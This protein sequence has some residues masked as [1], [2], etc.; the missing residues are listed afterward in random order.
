MKNETVL[1]T[2]ASGFIAVNAIAKL[3]AKGY[4]V[5]GSLRTMARQDEVRAMVQATG[6]QDVSGLEFVEADLVNANSW[7]LAMQ[8]VDYVMHIASPTPATRPD[9]ADAMVEMAVT[10][11]RNI[12]QA[13]YEEDVKRIVLTSASGAVLAGHKNH[14]EIFTEDDWSDLSSDLNAYQR[15]KTEAE[16]AAWDFVKSHKMEM[17]SILP[18]GVMGPVLGKDFSHSNQAIKDMFEGRMPF[19]L[20]LA[21]DYVDVRDVADLHVLA[22]ERPKAAGERF[23]ATSGD[24]ISYKEQASFLKAH[25]GVKAKKVSTK[26]L[27]NSLVKIVAHFNKQLRMP[28]SF[29]G[30]NTSCSSEKARALL[31]WQA[32]SGQEAIIATAESMFDFGLIDEA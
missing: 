25:F 2:G 17:A 27:P 30:Q 16:L 7:K 13:A 8:D 4:K 24:N 28:A 32:R 18:V 21:F 14:P 3:L 10:G 12:Y 15:S 26:V 29:L 5:R 19:L 20:N 31:G 22:M 9:S 23:L 11:V 6:Q 1:V